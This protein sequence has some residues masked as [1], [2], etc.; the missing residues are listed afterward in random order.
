MARRRAN[1]QGSISPRKDGRWD[2]AAWVLAASGEL[3]HVRTT[4]RTE[5]EADRKLTEL[6]ANHNN[7]IPVADKNCR[8]G[9][10]LDYWLEGFVRPTQRPNTYAQ[11]ETLV[12]LY[13]KPGLGKHYLHKLSIPVTQVYFTNLRA[14]GMTAS[15]IATIRKVLSSA[16]TRAVREELITRNVARLIELPSEQEEKKE[17]I[18]WNQGEVRRFLTV[19][20]SDRLHAAYLMLPTS[21]LRNGEL[22]G[23]RWQDVD[24]EKRMIHVRQQLTGSGRQMHIGPLKTKK[25]RRSLPL[26]AP[27]LEALRGHY[28]E[29]KAR[30]ITSE[31]VF[32][33]TT[34]EP[35]DPK[36]FLK[37]FQRLCERNGLRVVTVHDM[38]RTQATMLNHLGVPMRTIQHILGHSRMSTTEIYVLGN[39][40]E[41]Q[42]DAMRFIENHLTSESESA[43]PQGSLTRFFDSDS[44]RQLNRHQ[45][46]SPTFGSGSTL[47][48]A[49][50]IRTD[51]LFHAMKEPTT[52]AERVTEID[53]A[54]RVQ[55]RRLLF[56]T[57]AVNLAVKTTEGSDAELAA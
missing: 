3:K 6:K 20:R 10:Y 21:G 15:Y 5:Q 53:A 27:V 29:Q 7:G 14:A 44:N 12:R 43:E 40:D 16:L 17:R 9:D 56:G 26:I 49:Y 32:T 13:L 4:V 33:T 18:L 35:I 42:Q 54:L 48:G 19:I 8:L 34:G 22:L 45:G 24:A 1:G 11:K 39:E 41:G 57:V 50:R 30:G 28:E 46:E 51:D 31:L 23:L 55:R 25:S 37:A 52:L 2:V 36:N 47:G 38:R